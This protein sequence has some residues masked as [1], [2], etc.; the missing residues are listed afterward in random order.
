MGGLSRFAHK[1]DGEGHLNTY[2][3]STRPRGL[4]SGRKGLYKAHGFLIA[5]TAN[6]TLYLYTGKITGSVHDKFYVHPAL[7]T[8]LPGLFRI[9]NA[10]T[11][12]SVKCVKPADRAGL[13]FGEYKSGTLGTG[14]R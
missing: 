11:Y 3:F 4:P 6:S 7:N 13:L 2:G 10:L 9:L 1:A 12:V 8:G 14:N 5:A